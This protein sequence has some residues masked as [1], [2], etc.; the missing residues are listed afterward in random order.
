MRYLLLVLMILGCATMGAADYWTTT[1]WSDSTTYD[2]IV[3][4]NGSRQPGNLI[5]DAPD[6][7]N[8]E[9]LYSLPGAQNVYDMVISPNAVIFAATGDQN[10]DVFKSNDDGSTWDTT[11][12]LYLAARIYDMLF[13]D[14][15]LFA[16]GARANGYG[17]VFFTSD[18]G[19]TWGCGNLIPKIVFSLGE[20]GTNLLAGKGVSGA[21]IYISY[22]NGQ[23]WE[24][25]QGFSDTDFLSFLS[26]N[27]SIIIGGTGPNK[28][29]IVRSTNNGEIWEKVDS[30]NTSVNDMEKDISNLL[31]CC[32]ADGKVYKS[33]NSGIDWDSAGLLMDAQELNKLLYTDNEILY[34]A[35]RATGNI[36]VVYRSFDLGESWERTSDVVIG[37]SIFS[38]EETKNG[39]LLA[40]T[41]VD[42]SIFRVAYF[43]NGYLISKPYF[44]GT[45]NGS[46]KYG[47]I[48][49]SDS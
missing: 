42:A 45:T 16:G 26:V 31:F 15:T 8:W 25:K 13:S 48:Q 49:W 14:S 19:N 32:T 3:N 46:T 11:G 39:F 18:T 29:F 22:D 27:P 17:E 12:N 7:W 21:E 20:S 40:G 10:G 47:I 30:L 2:S 36:G 4:L 44:T 9:Y 23:T 5:L 1:N 24:L 41:N 38:I 37:Y 34:S 28:G 43:Q 6:V 33:A 35:G